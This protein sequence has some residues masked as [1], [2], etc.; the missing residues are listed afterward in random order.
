MVGGGDWMLNVA[1]V[2]GAEVGED[3]VG[4]LVEVRIGGFSCS[5]I[6]PS[7]FLSVFAVG[8]L[9]FLP[10]SSLMDTPVSLNCIQSICSGS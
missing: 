7:S 6:V 1:L 2:A 9:S 5:S 8:I 10:V 3:V 4:V